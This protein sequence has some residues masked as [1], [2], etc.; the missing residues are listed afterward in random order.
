MPT[1][2]RL[3]LVFSCLLLSPLVVMADELPKDT[4]KIETL[5]VEQAQRLAT[6][7]KG[8]WLKLN[9]LTTLSDEAA[10]ALAQHTGQVLYLNGLDRASFGAVRAL[11]SN[12]HIEMPNH[13]Y[14]LRYDIAA[15]VGT[16]LFLVLAGFAVWFVRRQSDA[17]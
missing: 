7:Y 16:V 13:W 6:E 1:L 4:N 14:L 15:L 12:P 11:R 10:K 17:D 8:T 9:G 3:L 5:T 2:A